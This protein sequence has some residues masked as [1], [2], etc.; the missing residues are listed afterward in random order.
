M[1]VRLDGTVIRLEGDCH[2]EQAETLVRLLQEGPARTV[3]I[4]QC[5]Q[6]HSALAQAL[7]AFGAPVHGEAED[8]FLRDLIQ[9]N[10]QPGMSTAGG[11]L[12]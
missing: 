12:Q 1:S 10:F 5:R 4:G 6:L 3:D 7:L 9:P 2:V 8:P 11:G